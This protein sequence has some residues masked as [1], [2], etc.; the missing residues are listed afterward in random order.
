MVGTRR[1]IERI[2]HRL[3]APGI[4]A[5]SAAMSRLP[6]VLSGAVY[7]TATVAQVLKPPCWQPVC[8][9]C[10]AHHHAA[11]RRPAC[12]IVQAIRME[13]PERLAAFCRAIQAASPWT[14]IY[15]RGLGHVGYD[16]PA[17]MAGAFVACAH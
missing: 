15:A 5:K 8:S 12:D 6:R 9:A 7:G 14:A 1:A 11:A 4:T 3:T 16:D 10:W 13:N 17:I 2:E